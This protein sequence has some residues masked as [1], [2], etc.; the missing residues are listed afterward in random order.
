M[1]SEYVVE[2][3]GILDLVKKLKKKY[4]RLLQM[5]LDFHGHSSRKNVFCYGPNYS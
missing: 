2:I 3:K 5:F 1:K 4:G